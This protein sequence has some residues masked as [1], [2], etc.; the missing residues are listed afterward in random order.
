MSVLLS[1]TTSNQFLETSHALTLK[2]HA[3]DL[4]YEF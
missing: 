2:I 3:K 4:Q 1:L